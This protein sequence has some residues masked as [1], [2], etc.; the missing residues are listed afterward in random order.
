[1]DK[2]S[3]TDSNRKLA[4]IQIVEHIEPHNN[5]DSL[6]LATVLGWQIVTRIGEA[7]IGEL[8]VYCEIDSVLPNEEWL[9]PAVKDRVAKSNRDTFRLKTI[10]L[11]GEYSQGLI[12]PLVVDMP[13]DTTKITKEDV[14]KDVTS[15]LGIVK[16]EPPALSGAYAMYQTNSRN[17]FPTHILDKTDETRVQ[18]VPKLFK[19]LQHKP[20]YA[21]VKCDGTS[22][23]FF[24]GLPSLFETDSGDESEIQTDPMK[25][26][27]LEPE[28]IV[29]S[30]NQ[31]RHKPQNLKVC[32]YWYIAQ[33]YNLEEKLN[34]V[35]HIAI[36]GE[37]CGP[38][39]QKNL[40]GLKDL[41][42]FVFNVVD[43]REPKGRKLPYNEMMAM[44]KY[45]ELKT[46]PIE[47]TGDSFEYESIK[48]VL[49]AAEGKYPKS[50][51]QREGLVF[52]S[53]DQRISFK[54]INNRYLLR[55]E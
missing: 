38:N 43:L 54:A 14:G 55:C 42:L 40:L 3:N 1:M 6:E 27:M 13:F 35:P 33:K 51:R 8:I 28:L 18:S 46:A 52:R 41:E 48:D 4:S 21:T 2:E 7:K 15:E 29:C 36:Q 22:V 19:L 20:Y 10:K 9:P 16:Y 50:K 47:E 11:R 17:P 23:T 44:C 49:G 53:K 12:V 32:P 25:T 37:I 30:R 5:A 24:I 31:I 34:K 45:L 39:V 26:S